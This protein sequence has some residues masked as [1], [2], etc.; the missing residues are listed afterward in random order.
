[1]AVIVNLFILLVF[2]ATLLF[3]SAPLI[4]NKVGLLVLVVISLSWIVL[5]GIGFAIL[6]SRQVLLKS[7]YSFYVFFLLVLVNLFYFLSLIAGRFIEYFIPVI[8]I[9]AG[10][11][12]HLLFF[13]KKKKC[14]HNKPWTTPALAIVIILFFI[15]SCATNYSRYFSSNSHVNKYASPISYLENNTENGELIFHLSWS[16]FPTL[17]YFNHTNTYI[18]GMDPTFMYLKDPNKYWLWTHISYGIKHSEEVVPK[19]KMVCK[20]NSP[21]DVY[22]ALKENFPIRYIFV[23]NIH[24]YQNFVY[25]LKSSPDLFKESPRKDYFI[26]TAIFE[27]L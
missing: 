19:H 13:N 5:P 7:K 12:C 2:L 6:V 1:M 21:K 15:V 9:F 10:M 14:P 17:F 4:A 27:I 3:T 26:D 8:V 18:S 24:S 16:D 25:M 22:E 20:I 23:E 11:S